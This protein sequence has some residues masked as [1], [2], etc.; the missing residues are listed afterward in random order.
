GLVIAVLSVLCIITL[1]VFAYRSIIAGRSTYYCI[2][3]CAATSMFMFQAILNVFGSVDLLPLTGVTFPFV[4][5][6]GT[7]MIV[8]WG[9]LAFLKAADTRQN[10]SLAVRV[11]EKDPDKGLASVESVS[12][13]D[14]YD[15]EDLYA[16]L[17]EEYRK[18][19][20]KAVKA[21]EKKIRK[22][23]EKQARKEEKKQAHREEP[24]RPAGTPGVRK[25]E[26]QHPKAVSYTEV[27]DDDFFGKFNPP[28]K[29]AKPK[30]EEDGP[31]TLDDIF[32]E[33]GMFNSDGKGGKR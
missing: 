15:P 8:S 30:A 13:V 18:P 20:R 16:L 31:L 7:S 2:A 28:S 33:N 10:A 22:T 27:S 23:E 17:G 3:A 24:E 4:S 26:P 6:G 5:S 29:T 12:A 32:G 14:I 21:E 11:H 19:A 1:A 25:E 9:M